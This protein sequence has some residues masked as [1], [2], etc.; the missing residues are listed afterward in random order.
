MRTVVVICGGRSAEHDVSIMSAR[1]V[2]TELAGKGFPVHLLGIDSRGH[3]MTSGE[4]TDHF[5]DL[6]E[7]V[8]VPSSDGWIGYLCGLSPE[9]TVIFPVLHGPY[10][11]DGTIQGLFELLGI[12][13][14]GSGVGASAVGMNKIYTK[15][16]LIAEGIPVLPF[17]MFHQKEWEENRGEQLKHIERTLPSPWFVKPSSMG[18]SIGITRVDEATDL[19][20][21]VDIAFR[22]DE[23][24][25]VEKGIEAREIEVSVLGNLEPRVSVPGEI[26]PGDR[27]YS[28]QAKYFDRGS[29]LLVP[30]PLSEEQVEQVQS[31]ALRCYRCLQLE[32]MARVDFL[33]DRSSQEIWVNEP[34]TIPGFTQISM[35]PRLWE[36]SGLSCGE[37]LEKLIEL[38]EERSQRRQRLSIQVEYW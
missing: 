22:Y 19:P 27:F 15:R 3:T 37:L 35:Y 31:L 1:T 33:M 24:V 17:T 25:I 26:V 14:V 11:E 6:P 23:S 36:A 28:Y 5:P 30:A 38:A 4:L 13:Y 32:G 34:N 8:E 9:R 20:A 18:S 12:P 2:V 16:L 10:G 29:R 7:G 21:A